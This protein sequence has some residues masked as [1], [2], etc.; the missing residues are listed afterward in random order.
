MDTVIRTAAIYLVL[1]VVFRI[2]GQRSIAQITTF[3]F[4]LLLVIGEAVQ[5]ALVGDDFS[6]TN[7]LLI[8]V[9]FIALDIL[10]S[11]LKELS[12]GV[13]KVLDGTPLVIVEDGKLLA[14]RMHKERI[15]AAD[16]LSAA[17]AAHGLERLEQIKYA[18]LERSGGISI[19]P[20]QKR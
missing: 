1:L 15:D 4:V 3:D 5:N 17:R 2:A 12:P 9:T 14:D 7:A 20:L 19:V 16:I 13:E 18:I 8:V 11:S 10:M 6:L